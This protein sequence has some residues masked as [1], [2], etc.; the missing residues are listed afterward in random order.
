M[1][2]TVTE[3]TYR[4]DV[5]DGANRWEEPGRPDIIAATIKDARSQAETYVQREA[6]SCGEYEP[7]DAMTIWLTALDE[8]GEDAGAEENWRY[9][10]RPWDTYPD[11]DALELLDEITSIQ[12]ATIRESDWDALTDEQRALIQAHVTGPHR[13]GYMSEDD[14][15]YR[16]TTD[17]ERAVTARREN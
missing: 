13:P 16:L 1:N 15:V 6:E 3:T 10:L 5:S 12:S 8:D 9:F 4:L 2:T 11:E 17:T 7:G 14:D